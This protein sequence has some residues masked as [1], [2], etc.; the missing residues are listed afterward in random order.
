MNAHDMLDEAALEMASLY[1]LTSLPDDELEHYEAH[2][3]VCVLCR[4][5]VQ[6]LK[7]AAAALTLLAPAVAP[8]PSLRAKVLSR[9]RQERD[10]R[11]GERASTTEQRPWQHWDADRPQG[12]LFFALGQES[13]WERTGFDGI[14]IRRLFVDP[15]HDRV[16]M[17][18]R[19]A[20]GAAYPSHRHGSAEEC[21]VISGDLRV[22][23][24]V[25]HTG[26]YQCARGGSEHPVQSTENGCLLFIVSS[27]HD[28]LLT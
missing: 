6:S 7:D 11:P 25:M 28:E 27:M 18:V 10:R 2:L 3:Q 24:T 19:M 15:S 16:T 20:P 4:Q 5:E 21:Y 23:D 1:A 22:G 13:Q 12:D 9:F 14:D 26:D 8:P 17:L